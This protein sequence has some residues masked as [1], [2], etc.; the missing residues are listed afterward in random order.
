MN[1]EIIRDLQNF[2]QDVNKEQVGL[3]ASIS[4]VFLQLSITENKRKEKG[5]RNICKKFIQKHGTEKSGLNT[6]NKI[7]SGIDCWIFNTSKMQI[8]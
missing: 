6:T 4:I 3:N 1:N 2:N 5:N 7:Q 8:S